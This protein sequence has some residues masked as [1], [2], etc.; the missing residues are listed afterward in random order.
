MATIERPNAA[1]HRPEAEYFREL[2]SRAGI[3]H[4][5]AARALD[6]DERT[7]RYFA[8]GQKPMPYPVQYCLE[9]LAAGG[10]AESG[11]PGVDVSAW[12]QAAVRPITARDAGRLIVGTGAGGWVFG[13]VR[14]DGFGPV[15]EGLTSEGTTPVAAIASY[16]L[17]DDAEGVGP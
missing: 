15:I 4:R 7:M 3:S 16:T 10:V 6:L 13:R 12:H 9:A 14:A 11:A 8:S 1:N 17:I 5:A 2:V